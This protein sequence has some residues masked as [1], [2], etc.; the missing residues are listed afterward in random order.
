MIKS[1][2]ILTDT[3]LPQYLDCIQ[4][5]ELLIYNKLEESD[6]SIDSFSFYTSVSAVFS[7]K[8]EGEDIALDSYIKHKRFGIEFLPN[9][10]KKIDDIYQAYQFAQHNFCTKENIESA[11][12]ILS[13]NIL[14]SSKQG[15]IRKDNM[16]V[17]TDDGRIEYV[18]ASP[19][20]V[21][22]EMQKWYED[23]QLLQQNH[24]SLHEIFYYAALL[25]LTFVKIHPFDDGNG[26]TARLIEKWF[27]A[28]KLGQ[29]AWYI[30]SE[31]NYYNHHNQY[32]TTI[33]KLGLEYD[34]LDYTQSLDFL[35]LLPQ[36]LKIDKN[37]L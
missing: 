19:I 9:Y 25:H 36:S 30:Q 32:Y 2:K 6:L 16:F 20:K 10:T 18:A 26:R 27:L 35:L 28:E 15:K 8:I 11:H 7:S 23:L 37:Y 3:L 1:F 13:K 29:K 21:E 12:K 5:D 33:R 17:I 14:P 4:E 24:L 22:D 34:D 31:K